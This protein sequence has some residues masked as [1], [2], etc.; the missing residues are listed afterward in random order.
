MRRFLLLHLLLLLLLPGL[1]LRSPEAQACSSCG[2]GG[3]DPVVLNPSESQKFYLGLSHQWGFREVDAKGE[4]RRSYGPKSKDLVELAFAQRLSPALFGS[5]VIDYARN[6]RDG[7]TA[8]GWGDCSANLRYTIL[9]PSM[10]DPLLPQIQLL[11]NHRLAIGRSIF[12]A[13]KEH[14][15]DVFGAGY[16]E[17]APGIDVWWGMLP[18]V[19]GAS[20][21]Y[22]IPSAKEIDSGS[23]K[24][25]HV[26]KGIVTVGYMPNPS[27]KVLTGVVSER[28][29]GTELDGQLQPDSDRRSNDV[30]LTVETLRV[31]QDNLRFILS[32][33]AAWGEVKNTTRGWST[34]L[35]WMRA[36]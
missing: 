28:R 26:Q 11:L 13:K 21:I 6:E 24:M 3:A 29:Q 36:L 16:A 9:Q 25:G 18:L 12:D 30:F 19:G 10:L 1:L 22:G 14:Y 17:T 2:S 31:E 32:R 35:A 4:E 7:Q 5:L 8:S 20:F 34:T 33:K 27:F 23:L 15:L